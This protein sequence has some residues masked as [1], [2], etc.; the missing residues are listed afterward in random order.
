MR[1]GS[2]FLNDVVSS[3]VV[4]DVQHSSQSSRQARARLSIN[5]KDGRF[6]RSRFVLS[7]T[8]S[9]LSRQDGVTV[10]VR[11]QRRRVRLAQRTCRCDEWL[12]FRR[13][14]DI[15][16]SNPSSKRS[17]LLS[18]PSGAHRSDSASCGDKHRQ[19]LRESVVAIQSSRPPSRYEECPSVS[20]WLEKMQS[21][22]TLV[23]EWK[24]L[25]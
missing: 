15:D 13:E 14:L 8:L 4:L 25:G 7:L 17:S 23:L 18:Q 3:L 21:L 12:R 9:Q 24:E 5:V 16:R 22:S 11:K 2:P 10:C 19:I 1:H 20:E 6:V